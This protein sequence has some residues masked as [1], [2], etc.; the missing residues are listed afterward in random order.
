[1][2]DPTPADQLNELAKEIFVGLAI[3][4]GPQNWDWNPIAQG[5]FNAATSFFAAQ[6]QASQPQTS[7]PSTDPSTPPADASAAPIAGAAPAVPPAVPPATPAPDPTAAATP[8]PA[9]TQS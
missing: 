6:A 4:A 1:M 5:A 2:S 3:E 7:V 8:D 9:Q